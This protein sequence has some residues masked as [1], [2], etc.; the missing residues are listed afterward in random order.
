MMRVSPSRLVIPWSACGASP[1]LGVSEIGAGSLSG[2]VEDESR[3]RGMAP[4]YAR[5]GLGEPHEPVI[6]M[7]VLRGEGSARFPTLPAVDSQ[8]PRGQQP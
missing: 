6:F 7:V 8:L 5:V 2:K 3:S 4:S 1:R